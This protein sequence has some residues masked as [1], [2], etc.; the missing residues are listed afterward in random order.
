M[1]QICPGELLFL[2]FVAGPDDRAATRR[3]LAVGQGANY[4]GNGGGALWQKRVGRRTGTPI[5]AGC[6]LCGYSNRRER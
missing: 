5:A 1:R 2:D 6:G 4:L 3:G